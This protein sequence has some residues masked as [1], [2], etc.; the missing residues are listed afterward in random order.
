M[1]KP[2]ISVLIDI[3]NRERFIEKAINSVLGAPISVEEKAVWSFSSPVFFARADV[4][5]SPD[6]GLGH[7][8]DNRAERSTPG[9]IR[10]EAVSVD[11]YVR[12]SGPPDFIKC[13]VEGAEVEVFRGAEKLLNERPPIILCEMHGEENRQTLLKAFADLSYRCEPCGKNHILAQHTK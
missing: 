7:V 5:V 2:P 10:V 9:T 11:E 1:A 6:R 8:V 13:D 4:E 3:Y 12:K